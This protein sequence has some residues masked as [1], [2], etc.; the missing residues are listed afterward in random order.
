MTILKV[1]FYISFLEDT[2]AFSDQRNIET[3]SMS[4]LSSIPKQKIYFLKIAL[5]PP[6]NSFLAEWKMTILKVVFYISFL[7]VFSDQRNM[8]TKSMPFLS[9]SRT[10]NYIT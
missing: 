7:E 1:V 4:F 3:K 5:W 10:K 2:P 8:E 6:P 9:Q